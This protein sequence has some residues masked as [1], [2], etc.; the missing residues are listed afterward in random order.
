MLCLVL[1]SLVQGRR[2]HP[3]VSPVEGR[4]D[5]WWTGVSGVGESEGDGTV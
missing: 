3:E 1:G 5:E 4:E 2:G